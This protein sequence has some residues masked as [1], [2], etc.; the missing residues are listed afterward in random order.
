MS[1]LDPIDPRLLEGMRVD[2]RFLR[3]LTNRHT[4]ETLS[5]IDDAPLRISFRPSVAARDERSLLSVPRSVAALVD[6]LTISLTGTKPTALLSFLRS[7]KYL[8]VLTVRA[9]DALGHGASRDITRAIARHSVSLRALRLDGIPADMREFRPDFC[10]PSL[11]SLCLEYPGTPAARRKLFA[12]IAKCG[13]SETLEELRVN[14]FPRE[15][16]PAL[17]V[18]DVRA[19]DERDPA[20]VARFVERFAATFPSVEWLSVASPPAPPLPGPDPAPAVRTLRRFPVGV[21]LRAMF[22]NLNTVAL[23]PTAPAAFGVQPFW[24][25]NEAG[26]REF[27]T[28]P[29]PIAVHQFPVIREK[30]ALYH[31]SCIPR[32]LSILVP[33]RRE[34]TVGCVRRMLETIGGLTR[35]TRGRD[36]DGLVDLANALSCLGNLIERDVVHVMIAHRLAT[37]KD[38]RSLL[39]I[40]G[41]KRQ[42]NQ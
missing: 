2:E 26:A 29:H 19:Q 42:K 34:E 24:I 8:R 10:A 28:R 11:R 21:D 14:F 5:E 16:L 12:P 4:P 22:P 27:V 18:L 17:R 36:L 37:T 7:A 23:R 3:F 13:L 33:C 39:R 41:V 6:A 20:E 38:F 1:L 35:E 32:H 25:A 30:L 9:R 40:C 15:P 31:R